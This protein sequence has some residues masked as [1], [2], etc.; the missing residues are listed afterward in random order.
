MTVQLC[1]G[2]KSVRAKYKIFILLVVSMLFMGCMKTETI[3]PA[4]DEQVK[5]RIESI[6]KVG[7]LSGHDISEYK[8]RVHDVQILDD[9]VSLQLIAAPGLSTDHTYRIAVGRSA[10][11]F[12][13]LFTDEKFVDLDTVHICWQYPISDVKG[14]V[15]LVS[16]LR[17]DLSRE[18][19]S[20]I[21][22]KR[23]DK[24]NIVDIADYYWQ[25]I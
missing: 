2:E 11:I 13:A 4:V 25:N 23:F 3:E 22:W 19:S 8:R 17:I 10:L 12:E 24:A 20:T 5:E 7:R 9:I 15:E 21:N 6:S 18:T 1:G 14:Q 16:I